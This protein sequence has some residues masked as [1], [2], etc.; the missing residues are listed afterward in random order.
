M[1]ELVFRTD[2]FRERTMCCRHRNKI[3]LFSLFI[4]KRICEKI[5][6]T[7]IFIQIEQKNGNVLKICA[8]IDAAGHDRYGEILRFPFCE[9]SYPGWIGR[10]GV[11]GKKAG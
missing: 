5:I 11:D 4:K 9:V 3:K 8:G 1:A 2:K 6:C 10:G 7:V